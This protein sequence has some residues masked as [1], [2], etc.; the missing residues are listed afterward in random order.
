MS[1]LNSSYLLLLWSLLSTAEIASNICRHND[2]LSDLLANPGTTKGARDGVCR[3]RGELAATST[4]S[5]KGAASAPAPSA[6]HLPAL[7]WT[8]TSAPAICGKLCMQ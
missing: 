4:C 2:D 1:F 6:Q 5:T 7:T 8:C 3:M